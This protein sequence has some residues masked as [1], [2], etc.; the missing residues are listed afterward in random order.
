[1]WINVCFPVLRGNKFGLETNYLAICALT[2]ERGGYVSALRTDFM[3][4]NPSAD[5]MANLIS[6]E[7]YWALN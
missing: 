3:T 7:F 1:M 2:S 5:F 4:T 6:G